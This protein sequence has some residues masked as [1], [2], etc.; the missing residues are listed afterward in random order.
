MYIYIIHDILIFEICVEWIVSV[1]LVRGGSE[2]REQDREGYREA[3]VDRTAASPPQ[4]HPGHPTCP[5]LSYS[6]TDDPSIFLSPSGSSLIALI[7]LARNCLQLEVAS[8]INT[9]GG[10]TNF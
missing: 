6:Q 4:D 2:E 9:S 3:R 1:V 7:V 10:P 8:L 5:L